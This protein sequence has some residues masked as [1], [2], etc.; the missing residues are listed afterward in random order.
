MPIYLYICIRYFFFFFFFYDQTYLVMT[1]KL[2][3][4]YM[5][6]NQFSIQSSLKS[7][8]MIL[9]Q[10]KLFHLRRD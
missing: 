6:H 7:F 1:M 2:D 9:F 8:L 3:L 5:F 10:R 4:K